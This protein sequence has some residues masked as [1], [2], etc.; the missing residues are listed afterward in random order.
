MFAAIVRVLIEGEKIGKADN[1]VFHRTNQ[2]TIDL[3][4][5]DGHTPATNFGSRSWES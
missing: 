5:S 3:R 2:T 1:K 4:Q